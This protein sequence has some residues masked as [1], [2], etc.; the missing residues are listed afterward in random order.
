MRIFAV[1][2]LIAICGCAQKK[3]SYEALS[4]DPEKA[5]AQIQRWVPVGTSQI[6]AERIMEQHDFSCSV[7]TNSGFE[8]VSKR[9]DFL[10]CDHREPAGRPVVRR[11]QAAL[12]LTNGD[13][14]G[15]KVSTGLIG[16]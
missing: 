16:P 7:M 1:A 13:V 11:W 12:F 4:D 6:E 14:A 10:Y 15:V 2:L 3:A 5:S 8:D 9:G